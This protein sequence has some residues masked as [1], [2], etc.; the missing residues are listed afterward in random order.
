MQQIQ[1]LLHA[2]PDL[3]PL[4]LQRPPPHLLPPPQRKA[5]GKEGNCADKTNDKITHSVF[6]IMPPAFYTNSGIQFL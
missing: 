3:P 2:L 1:R 5:R 4:Q 6:K